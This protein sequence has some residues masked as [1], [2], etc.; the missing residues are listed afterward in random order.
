MNDWKEK[1]PTHNTLD[2]I[3]NFCVCK[4][5]IGNGRL[6]SKEPQ[7]KDTTDHS[8]NRKSNRPKHTTEIKQTRAQNGDTTTRE[9]NGDKTDQGTKRR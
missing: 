3:Y 8:T 7:N 2:L 1:A 9:Q 6:H 5:M 4:L